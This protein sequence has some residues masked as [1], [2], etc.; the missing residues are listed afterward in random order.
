[1][2]TLTKSPAL[3][4]L[5]GNIQEAT[6]FIQGLSAQELGEAHETKQD[7]LT[8][9][10]LERQH[11]HASELNRRLNWAFEP[12]V[13]LL[14]DGDTAMCLDDITSSND[15]DDAGVSAIDEALEILCAEINCIKKTYSRI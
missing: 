10:I 9:Q 1:M 4:E 14:I 8:E 11:L 6:A 7:Y 3:T 2:L 15:F 13:D 5:L 12:A